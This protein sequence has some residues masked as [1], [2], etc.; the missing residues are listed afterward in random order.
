MAGLSGVH[1]SPLRGQGAF[2]MR[3]GVAERLRRVMELPSTTDAQA[4][5]MFE[6]F[7]LLVAPEHMGTKFKVLC[8]GA[9]GPWTDTL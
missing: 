3:L 1:C 5:R 7:K 9:G 6:D 2:L 4:A 8:L